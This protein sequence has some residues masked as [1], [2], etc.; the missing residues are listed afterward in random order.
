MTSTFTSTYPRPTVPLRVPECQ[1][2][3]LMPLETPPP[4]PDLPKLP[5]SRKRTAD[6]S[7]TVTTHLLLAA[8]PRSTPDVPLPDPPTWT[9]DKAQWKD[10][11]RAKADEILSTKQ[12]QLAGKL[13]GAPSRQPLWICVNRYRRK[14]ARTTGHGASITLFFAHATGYPKEVRTCHFSDNCVL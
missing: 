10:A 4:C 7:F 13:D 14:N 3:S 12:R 8:F 11:V 9:E 1:T 5:S 6:S 2:H